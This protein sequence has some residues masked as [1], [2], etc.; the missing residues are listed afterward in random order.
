MGNFLETMQRFKE[1]KTVFSASFHFDVRWLYYSRS[2]EFKESEAHCGVN[3][4]TV[5]LTVVKF[6]TTVGFHCKN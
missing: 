6:Q 5:N 3:F 1:M 2:H 4:T